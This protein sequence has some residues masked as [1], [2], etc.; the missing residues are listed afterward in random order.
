MQLNIKN[1]CGFKSANVEINGITVI[2]GNNNTGKSSIGKTL[3]LLFTSLYDLRNTIKNY[4]IDAIESLLEEWLDSIEYGTTLKKCSELIVERQKEFKKEPEKLNT[5]LENTFKKDILIQF[6]SLDI[7]DKDDE[8]DLRDIMNQI[9]SLNYASLAEK[10]KEIFNIT[11]EEYKNQILNRNIDS[12]FDGLFSNIRVKDTFSEINL[13]FENQDYNF[14]IQDSKAIKSETI[15]KSHPQ[16]IYIDNPFV[17]DNI[18]NNLRYTSIIKKNLLDLII[19]PK[20]KNLS[21]EILTQKYF[22]EIFNKVIS[23]GEL[24][25]RKNNYKYEYDN[26][27]FPISNISTGLKVFLI[28]KTLLNN[29]SIKDNS[30]LIL[31]E[32]EIHL[33]P[34]WQ[35]VFAEILVLLQK[36]FGLHI[37]LTTHSPYFLKAIEKY[38]STHDITKKCNY[39][40]TDSEESFCTIKDV[41]LITE[42]IYKKFYTPFKN[43]DT[44]R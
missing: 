44:G 5:Y 20:Q 13:K 25:K 15:M 41:T 8:E 34:E 16:V 29:G 6:N 36:T 38:S 42:E 39:Y 33:H 28:I 18:T 4:R 31:D 2:A 9:S 11:D 37:L 35:L 12:I 19:K 23:I 43:L 7:Y 14:I 22:N 1:I 40:L 27:E 26:I 10:I 32:P 3:F 17:I 30:I 24:Q 21:F